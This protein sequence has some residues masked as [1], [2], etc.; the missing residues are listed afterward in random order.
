[1]STWPYVLIGC[2]EVLIGCL[3]SP[4]GRPMSTWPYVYQ[5]V[6]SSYYNLFTALNTPALSYVHLQLYVHPMHVY[7]PNTHPLHTLYTPCIRL[8]KQPIKQAGAVLTVI[9]ASLV[10]SDND[11]EAIERQARR[12]ARINNLL[13][14][15]NDLLNIYKHL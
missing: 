1:M 9:A 5:K 7:T 14:P 2:L 8:I 13:T 11:L 15:L 4:P 6:L 12:E 10:K 3:D